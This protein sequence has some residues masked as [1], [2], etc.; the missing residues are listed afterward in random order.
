MRGCV[1]AQMGTKPSHRNSVY[2]DN[3]ALFGEGKESTSEDGMPISS[4]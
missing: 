2:D 1:H 4:H 3:S